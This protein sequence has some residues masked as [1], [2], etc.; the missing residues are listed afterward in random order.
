[1]SE[2]VDVA[3]RRTCL[4]PGGIKAVLEYGR[5][6]PSGL[7]LKNAD[8]YRRSSSPRGDLTKRIRPTGFRRVQEF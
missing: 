8:P 3:A 5:R 1:M 7:E 6:P 2:A 4:A